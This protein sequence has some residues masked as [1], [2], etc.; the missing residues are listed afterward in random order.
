MPTKIVSSE[1]ESLW[2]KINEEDLA[3][4]TGQFKDHVLLSTNNGRYITKLN[5]MAVPIEIMQNLIDTI[6]ISQR[7]NCNVILRFG[8]TLSEQLDCREPHPPVG[9]HLTAVVFLEN[10]KM[11]KL[12]ENDFIITTAFKEFVEQSGSGGPLA[13]PEGACCPVIRP[14]G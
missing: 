5:E 2:G 13:P 14:G 3:K 10:D 1:S 6:N 12:N 11:A 8:V 4:I 9:D 7:K